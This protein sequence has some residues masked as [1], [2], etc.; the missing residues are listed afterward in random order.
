[1]G[2]S[3]IAAGVEV[4]KKQQDRG[5]ATVDETDADLAARL[6]EHADAL[7]CE[8]AVAATVVEVYAGGRS[9][10]TAASVAEVAPTTAAKTLHLLGEQVSP[11]GP[12]GRE[13]VRDWLDATLSR[14][15]AME[16]SG[17]SERAFALAAYVETHEPIPGAREAVAATLSTGL[18]GGEPL[19]ETMSSVSDLRES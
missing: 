3:D 14:T 7:P 17:V 8:P 19:A 12:P 5:V 10:E 4:T 1:M 2:L 6:A 11:V 15:E 18:G 16:L 13:I 9:I